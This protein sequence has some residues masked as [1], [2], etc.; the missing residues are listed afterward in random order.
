VPKTKPPADEG[1]FFLSDESA[2]L[3]PKVNPLV[4]FSPEASAPV[5]PPKLNFGASSC[6]VSFCALSPPAVVFVLSFT[7]PKTKPVLE[8]LPASLEGFDFALSSS[9]AFPALDPNTKPLLGAGVVSFVEDDEPKV[10]FGGESFESVPDFVASV[11]PNENPADPVA[12]ED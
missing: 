10:N 4:D 12:D 2:L 9:E 6:F 5:A 8:E 11:L 7:E 3:A 1:G